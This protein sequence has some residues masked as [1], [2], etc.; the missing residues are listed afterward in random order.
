MGLLINGRWHDQWYET[1]ANGGNFVRG[2]SQFRNWVTVDG[3][4]G[5][6]GHAGFKAESG[7]YHLYVSYACPWANR[8]LIFR[9]LKGLEQH[10]SVSAVNWVMREHGWTFEPGPGVIADP[11]QNADFM[12]EIYTRADAGYTGRVT[13]PVLWDLERDELVSNESADIIRMFNSAFDKVGANGRDFY[14]AKHRAEIDELNEWIYHS[15][16]NGVYKAGFATSQTA[17]E[18]AVQTLFNTLEELE[19]VLS[20]R[21]YLVGSDVTEADWRLFTTLVRF[22]PVYVS[23]FKCNLA[24]LKDFPNLWGYTCEL[25]QMPGIADTIHMDHI[26]GHY[27]QSHDT[28]NPH[29][30]V[31]MGPVLDYAEPHGRDKLATRVA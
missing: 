19:S 4:A 1:E 25:Y 15:V 21:R 22:D 7:R 31:P 13:V 16:N 29:F 30:I 28:I 12:H 26:K 9:A 18:N 2:D 8:T 17:Y 5:P 20:K 14:P 6:T 27:F 3:S 10:I 24:R 23:H 11:L